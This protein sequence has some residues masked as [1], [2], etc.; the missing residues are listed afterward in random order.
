[1]KERVKKHKYV[2][3]SI[4]IKRKQKTE[5]REERQNPGILQHLE[6]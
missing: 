5:E 1:M 3:I 4:E 6:N 2:I